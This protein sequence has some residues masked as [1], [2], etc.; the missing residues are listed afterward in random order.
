MAL[1]I[2]VDFNAN[3]V[4]F[5]GQVNKMA[6]QLDKFQNKTES[7]AA[8]ANKALSS[9]GVGISVAGLAAFVKSGIDAADALNDMADRTGIAVEKLAG[10][11]LATKLADTDMESFAASINR[12]SVNIGK[13]A[14]DFKQL[15]ITA[16]DPVEAF[17]Q[18]SDVFRNIEDPQTRAALGAKALGKSYAEMAT[19]LMQGSDAL[20]DQIDQGQK[21]SGITTDQA[22]A[23]AEF[24]DKLDTLNQQMSTLSVQVGGPAVSALLAFGDAIAFA[25]QQADGFHPLDFLDAAGYAGSGD[26]GKLAYLNKQIKETGQEIAKIQNQ[27]PMGSL[28]DAV[29]GNNI[30]ELD[31]KMISLTKSRDA[32]LKP[33]STQAV[34]I[35]PASQAAVQKFIASTETATNATKA[36]SAAHR[37]GAT[38]QQKH[39][40][41]IAKTIE[42]LQFEI[43][44]I[45]QST[46]QQQKLNEI[47]NSTVGATDAEAEAITRLIDVKYADVA[48]TERQ[49]A[50]WDQLVS[51]AN[52][53]YDL[54]KNIGELSRSNM[55]VDSLSGGIGNIQDQLNA[56]QINQEQAKAL[57][58]QLGRGFNESFIDPAKSST[59]QLSEYGVQ[60]ARNMQS[61]F[62]DFLFDPFAKGSENMLASFANIIKRMAAEAASAQIM[63]ALFGATGKQDGGGL[64]GT[65][66]SAVVGGALGAFG[67]GSAGGVDAFGAN[68]S[69]RIVAGIRHAGGMVGGGHTVSA[70]L[71]QFARAPRLHNGGYVLKADEVP[72]I[73]QTGERVLNRKEAASYNA[74]GGDVQISTTV[75]VKGNGNQ[76]NAQALGNMI[77]ARIKQVIVTEKRP[78]GLL[79]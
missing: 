41:A 66:F 26:S 74:G 50:M 18:L 48:A 69:G 62:A 40:E 5:E 10:F 23:A 58:D 71:A 34:I 8:R 24:N 46:E 47:R 72:T 42:N 63:Q 79:A 55:T 33:P 32:L 73:L 38:D 25:A 29:F 35:P 51:D 45:G 22:K 15:G 30:E 4:K 52:D 14:E 54:R 7:M 64:I 6:G 53:Y 56:G 65:L 9:L 20:R 61:A 11:Q 67:G 17:L 60:A 36:H 27:G 68:S 2:T 3:L 39:A 44:I 1:G 13:N 43:S 57:Y 19:L 31:S 59:E 76:D 12:L 75:N 70:S 37:A 77:N 16:K 49:Q 28:M 21:M 78:G